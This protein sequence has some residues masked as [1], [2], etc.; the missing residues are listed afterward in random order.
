MVQDKILVPDT[1]MEELR[2]MPREDQ[3][4]VG[5]YGKRVID[6]AVQ[7]SVVRSQSKKLAPASCNDVPPILATKLNR[8]AVTKSNVFQDT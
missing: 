6:V 4:N 1:S 5:R 3:R 8:P 2:L 7:P